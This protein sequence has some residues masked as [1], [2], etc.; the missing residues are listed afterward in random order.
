MQQHSSYCT[1]R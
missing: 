1:V